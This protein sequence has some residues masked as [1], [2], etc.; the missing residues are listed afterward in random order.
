[1]NFGPL[2]GSSISPILFIRYVAEIPKPTTLNTYHSQFADDIKT[3]AYSKSLP[4]IQKCLQTNRSKLYLISAPAELQSRDLY[5]P[6]HSLT[7]QYQLKISRSFSAS[8]L[9]INSHSLNIS[10]NL[11][12]NCK[13]KDTSRLPQ[14]ATLIL[15]RWIA[16]S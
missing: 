15:L 9:I 8:S 1:M 4:I 6:S 11:T 3:Y 7:H 16:L 10:T 13:K 12:L 2:Q 14:S 5:N